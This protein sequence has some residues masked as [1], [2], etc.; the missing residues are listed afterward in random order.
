MLIKI[1]AK[2]MGALGGDVN[3]L[4]ELMTAPATKILDRWF[5]SEPLRATLATDAVIGA[6][7]SPQMPGTR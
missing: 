5:E 4:M 6:F 3:K 7:A 1:S 2:A